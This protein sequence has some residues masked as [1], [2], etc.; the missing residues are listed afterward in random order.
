[1]QGLKFAQHF[2][3]RRKQLGLTQ[4]DVAAYVGI[5]SAAVSKWEQGL[6]Y[7]DLT[8]LP[9]LATLLDMTIDALLGYEP[10]LTRNKI[11]ELYSNFAKRLAEESFETVQA[12]IEAMLKEYY[13]C[14][15]FLNRM[16]Q[17]YLNYYVKASNP[18]SVFQRIIELC[19]RTITHSDNYHLNQ[20]AHMLH[21]AVLLMS[22]KP[23][24]LLQYL[25][26]DIKIHYGAEQMIAQAH[27][28]LGDVQKAKLMLQA[29]QFQYLFGLIGSSVESMMF[30]IDNT[31]RFDE[32]IRR[33]ELILATYNIISINIHLALA[34]YCKAA[35]GYMQQQRPDAAL[36]MVKCYYDACCKLT[37]P[38]KV[39]G[40]EFFDLIDEW[41]ENE[42]E[43]G[44]QTPRDEQSI[45][46]DM[47][48]IWTQNP[49]FA[50]LQE[51]DD[52]KA[53]MVNLRHT[54]K[55]S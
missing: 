15:P 4:G 35:A 7:P 1:M 6:S 46:S 54:L 44:T 47:L 51:N 24:E 41:L 2:T 20:E 25:G 55:L 16:A 53:I 34:F 10:Q 13:S 52:F 48:N 17:L 30:D 27:A 26:E 37:Y 9:K 3:M 49:I 23:Q 19:E 42:A 39:H 50:P 29:S 31:Q 12:D 36:R 8:L 33:I 45:K 14:Y 32:S 38:L 5:S 28:M 22:G 40:D 43:L 11:T 21:A 18:E